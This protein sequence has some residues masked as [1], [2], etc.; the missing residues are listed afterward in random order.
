MA[1]SGYNISNL[2]IKSQLEEVRFNNRQSYNISNLVIK[3][4]TGKIGF[5]RHSKILS[6]LYNKVHRNI[7]PQDC[8]YGHEVFYVDGT[9]VTLDDTAAN[10]AAFP[11]PESQKKGLGF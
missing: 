5:Y 6:L 9:E 11:Q 2:V 1:L 3:S 10:Q 8:W 4:Q 7:P